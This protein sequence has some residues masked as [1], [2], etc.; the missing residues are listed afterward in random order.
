MSRPANSEPKRG[1]KLL[2]IN[3]NNNSSSC[4]PKKDNSNNPIKL[5][6]HRS[7]AFLILEN[8]AVFEG[9]SCGAPKE[10]GGE[11]VFNTAMTGYQEILTDPSYRGQIVVMTYPLIGNTGINFEDVESHRPWVEG[12][13]VREM[14]RRPS[15]WRAKE[16]LQLYLEKQGIPAIE[17]IDT[18]Q[19]VKMI[20]EGGAQRA[21]LTTN[22]FNLDMLRQKVKEIPSI[23][24]LDLVSSVTCQAPY[25][26]DEGDYVWPDGYI[27]KEE[28]KFK[29]VV[30]DFGVKR[31]ILRQLVANG[32]Q[33]LVVP[34]NTSAETIL[35][36]KPDGL[37][38]SNGPGDPEPLSYAIATIKNLVGR[39]PIFG[40]CLGHQL[41]ALALG[42]QTYKLK[43][44]HHGANHPVKNLLTGKIEITSQN[45][46]FA[47]A[48]SSLPSQ[49]IL[50]HI[51][52]NDGTVEG[53]DYPELM[54][55]SVQYHPESSPGPHDSRYLFKKFFDLMSR[56]KPSYA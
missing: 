35:A 24:G 43:F 46:G 55:F 37:L 30:L 33:V 16:S 1:E 5:K 2:K 3:P 14:A 52:L 17:G 7:P 50:T 25:F 47:V 10:V 41:L 48:I 4:S 19:I 29:V 18:R 34:A 11:I 51:N 36:Y 13:V 49:A 42:G 31:H 38:L 28:K 8:G 44:G 12:F 26:F 54:A 21:L 56:L 27:K 40:I 39:L 20:R 53:I 45:H 9:F 32:A 15:N 22:C 23:V 6:N